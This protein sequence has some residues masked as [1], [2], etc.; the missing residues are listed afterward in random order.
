MDDVADG[1]LVLKI[2]KRWEVG[3][4]IGGRWTLTNG[5]RWE[6]GPQNTWEIGC[7][8]AKQAGDRSRI[9]LPYS[10]LHCLIMNYVISVHGL[11]SR[12]I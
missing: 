1:R 6:I 9:P 8:P 4:K 3:L 10:P 2:G 7:W 11:I 12:P 5:R